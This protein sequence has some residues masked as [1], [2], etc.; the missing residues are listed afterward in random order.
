MDRL[1]S[2]SYGSIPLNL[3]SSGTDWLRLC[4]ANDNNHYRPWTPSTTTTVD[5][6]WVSPPITRAATVTVTATAAGVEEKRKTLLWNLFKSHK[7]GNWLKPSL[8]GPVCYYGHSSVV[9]VVVVVVY[10]GPSDMLPLKEEMA[11]KA[12]QTGSQSVRSGRHLDRWSGWWWWE[13]FEKHRRHDWTGSQWV[14]RNK[15]NNIITTTT[16]WLTICGSGKS[17]RLL[18]CKETTVRSFR[19]KTNLT[20]W[21]ENKGWDLF[22]LLHRLYCS[23][24]PPHS[25]M[26][27]R[28]ADIV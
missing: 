10:R 20:F 12:N 17:T 7:P 15:K 1:K 18:R 23:R 4:Y 28:Q 2:P 9:T 6:N 19:T 11:V 21:L 27:G 13:T 24:P 14:W 8:Y 5:Y 16:V 26:A 22:L 25:S 3:R